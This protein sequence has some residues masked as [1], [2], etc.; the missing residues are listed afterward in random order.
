M[1]GARQPEVTGEVGRRDVALV[2]AL[3]ESGRLGRAVSLDE[4]ESAAVTAYQD[5][6]DQAIGLV[7]S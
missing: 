4:I 1:Q 2:Y 3:F 6:I 7:A 5:D